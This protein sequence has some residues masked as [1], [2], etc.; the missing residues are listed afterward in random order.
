[1]K[2]ERWK[3]VQELYHLALEREEG[4]RAAFLAEEC[5]GDSALRDEV[6]SLLTQV[7]GPTL[8]LEV[9]AVEVAAKD[10]AYSAGAA[11]YSHPAAIGRYRIVRLLGEG[12]MGAVY[13][14]E[15]DEPRRTVAVKVI[16]FG[17]ATPNQMRRFRQESQA[18]AR[19]QHPG[20][21]Q[22]YESNTADTGFGPQPYFAMELIR[23][24]PLQEYADKHQLNTRQRL[25]LIV[26]VCDAVQHAHQRGLI[27]RDLKP[28]NILVDETGQPKVL[29][30]GVARV[31]QADGGGPDLQP[32]MLTALGQIVGTLAYMSPEQVLGDPLE[33]DTRSDVYALGVILYELLAGRLP[34]DANQRDLPQAV[35]MIRE[36][37]PVALG[38]INRSYRGDV[39]TIVEKALEK[40]KSRRYASASD[41]GAD[42]ERY[43]RN[44]PITARPPSASYQLKKFGLRHRG[45]I[46]AL[47]A[48]FIVL[49]AGI[50]VATTMAL[51][52]R[53][54]EAEARAVSDFLQNDVLEQAGS[55][56]QAEANS[57]PS[58]HLEVRTALD[59][60]AARIPGKFA[61]Q[62]LVEASIRQTIGNAY[63]DLGFY[64]EA[65]RQDEL[66]LAIRRRVLGAADPETQRSLDRLAVVY[67]LQGQYAKAEP[68][69]QE[70][71]HV[72]ERLLG[73]N[74]PDT[75]DAMNN[76]ALLYRYEGKNALAEPLYIRAVEG[77]RLRK[78]V[79]A[80][81]VGTESNLAQL[82]NDEGKYAE[83][84]KLF[85]E[86][87]AGA[88]SAYGP[89]APGTFTIMN[90]LALLYSDQ[91]QL[92]RAEQLQRQA[93]EGDSRVEGADHPSTMM[94]L[95]NLARIYR[96]EGK[97]AEAETAFKRV[98]ETM[99][100]VL[101][102]DRPPTLTTMNL[103]GTVK[104]YEGD[105]PAA[106]Q[107][108]V[109]ALDGQRRVLGN[110]PS[111]A[112]SL[113]WLG[114][115]QL[116]QGK[117]EQ[118]ERS[119]REAVTMYQKVNPAGWQRYSAESFLGQALAEE[120]KYGDAESPLL[121]GYQGMLERRNKIPA[122]SK[123]DLTS[124]GE[125]I[126]QMYDK[127]PK[128]D[129][130]AEWRARVHADQP[131]AQ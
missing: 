6:A 61:K 125:Q 112:N 38:N 69:R 53:E 115:D 90:N 106:E 113:V 111:T 12:G 129:K 76:L 121:S 45:L 77:I 27:H 87:L 63:D 48:I 86:A 122:A 124:A 20:I 56:A 49:V 8:F 10:L 3:K 93:F 99:R 103:L 68:L 31:T 13:E 33:V 50:A 120:R 36:Q 24:L 84:E 52:A 73:D 22:I 74:H 2:A 114:R 85:E 105:Y 40:D 131:A 123:P 92:A 126:V 17:S 32:S 23:G 96:N 39:E 30:F 94:D 101:G 104:Y 128:P 42:I 117:T 21:A 78:L 18:L 43:L 119:F 102:E 57:T 98:L 28:G 91:G 72:R 62:P 66:A 46:A 130:A 97:Y 110:H 51:R 5:D 11:G 95:G 65:A 67:R 75:L 89:D 34:Y 88:P 70:L 41:L 82:Y 15:Q 9:A 60:A 71:L 44:E 118:A 7:T 55:S 59:R 80:Q 107:L 54:A 25:D 29:D 64:D 4:Q 109:R 81:S 127:W 100:R 108:F 19:L 79:N 14:A 26:K 58:P 16:R 47:A 37:E 83:A 1:M 116:K 35:H